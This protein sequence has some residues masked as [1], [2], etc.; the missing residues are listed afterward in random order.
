M[1]IPLAAN[2][3]MQNGWTKY[4]FRK[5]M[6]PWLPGEIAWR[7]DKQGFVNPQSEW[8]KSDLR[9]GVLDY[10]AADSLMF[11]KGLVDR[12]R[13]LQKYDVY[14]RQSANGGTISFK[15]IFNPLALEIWLRK[16]E[17]YLG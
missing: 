11:K 10:F 7:K 16:Y 8:L 1:L 6:A 3:K 9:E 2:L 12:K 17:G 4:I 15:D 5:A 13:L 14:C